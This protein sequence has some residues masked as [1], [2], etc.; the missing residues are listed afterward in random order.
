M[1]TV[2]VALA[3]LCWC[4]CCGCLLP[5]SVLTFSRSSLLSLLLTEVWTL[6]DPFCHVRLLHCSGGCTPRSSTASRRPQVWS[7][8]YTDPRGSLPP[9]HMSVRD[10]I[11]LM[12]I[13]FV[14]SSFPSTHSSLRCHFS[15]FFMPPWAST[16]LSS[17]LRSSRAFASLA[18]LS[19]SSS[20]LAPPALSSLS[21]R[22]LRSPFLFF[23]PLVLALFS[24]L[25]V[26]VVSHSSTSLPL[27][28]PVLHTPFLLRLHSLPIS[29]FVFALISPSSESRHG[30]V[31]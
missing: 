5:R 22:L 27:L 19:R 25:W 16:S 1:T 26:S 31:V 10:V 21:R 4:C 14:S 2:D 17:S 30:L 6:L 20:L 8:V 13:E 18:G 9:R 3:F 29:S 11:F 12:R 24:L 23:F 28:S 15:F 7:V